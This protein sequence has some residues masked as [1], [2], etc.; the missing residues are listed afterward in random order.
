MKEITVEQLLQLDKAVPVDVRSPGEFEESCIPGAVNIPLFSNEE[1]KEVGTLYKQKGSAEAKWKAMEI[2]SPKLPVLLSAIRDLRNNGKQPVVYCWRG[3][4]RSGSVAIFLEFS[5]VESV[6]LIGGYRAY[7]N[8]ILEQIPLHIPKQAV[9]LHGLTG[10]GKTELLKIL[11]AKGYPVLDLE[12]M[13]AHRGS[14]FGSIG[15]A[16]DG[17]NQKTF[18]SLLFEGL[19]KIKDSHYFIVE[20]ESQ[21]IGKAG[22]PDELYQRKLEG[23]NL[24]LEASLETRVMRLYNEYVCPNFHF[25]WFHNVISEKLQLLRKRFK[26]NVLHD[27]MMEFAGQKQY[28]QVIRILLEYYYDPRYT[29]KQLEYKNEFVTIDANHLEQA[30]KEIEGFLQKK[31]LFKASSLHNKKSSPM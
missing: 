1:R 23:Y 4:M 7:R 25:D 2:V 3:G 9:V 28:E 14:L 30:A 27:Q 10:T 15:F 11:E 6:R 22:Q 26:N 16:K 17:H 21:R 31:G 8:Y 18:D 24:L 5:G 19:R 13:A 29:F 20:A 12:E